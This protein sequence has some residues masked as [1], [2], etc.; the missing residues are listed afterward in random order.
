MTPQKRKFYS[1]DDG[2][3]KKPSRG[4]RSSK[5]LRLALDFGTKALKIAYHIAKGNKPAELAEVHP[6]NFDLKGTEA[7]MIIGFFEGEFVWGYRLNNLIEAGKV[8]EDDYISLLK[9]ALYSD[10]NTAQIQKEVQA[11][12]HRMKRTLEELLDQSLRAFINYAKST[13][14]NLPHNDDIESMDLDLYLSVPQMWTPVANR[15]MT[16][17]AGRVGVHS[18]RLV[19]EAE[20]A[21]AFVIAQDLKIGTNGLTSKPQDG[22]RIQLHVEK[23]PEG[24]LLSRLRGPCH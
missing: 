20:C 22:Q 9:L 17:A 18:V 21:A 13:I 23:N 2:L 6:L 11:K 7:P 3:T 24:S 16:A 5:I 12:L 15:I 14:K 1:R 8:G 19:Y 10:V 4:R